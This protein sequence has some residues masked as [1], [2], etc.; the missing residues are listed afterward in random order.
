M[1]VARDRKLANFCPDPHVDGMEVSEQ[2]GHRDRNGD[3]GM[4][5]A[6]GDWITIKKNDSK[7]RIRG[8]TEEKEMKMEIL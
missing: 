6:S 2:S 1:C 8:G 3:T 4:G 7:D 5:N